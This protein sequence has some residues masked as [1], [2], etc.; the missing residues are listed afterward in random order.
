MTTPLSRIPISNATTRAAGYRDG[1]ELLNDLRGNNGVVMHSLAAG[2]VMAHH[3]STMPAHGLAQ[4]GDSQRASANLEQVL[5]VVESWLEAHATRRDEAAAVLVNAALEQLAPAVPRCAVTPAPR[6][7]LPRRVR[8][9]AAIAA[10]CLV[11]GACGWSL[12][13]RFSA[14]S[15][16][17]L[18]DLQL[19]QRAERMAGLILEE[20]RYEKDLFINID[21][22]DRLESYARKWHEVRAGLYDELARAEKLNLSEQDLKTLR[23]IEIDLR[24]Y[25][26]GYER[27]LLM[28]R[29]GDIRTTQ[30]AN[31]EFTRFKRAAHRIEAA[32]AAISERAQQRAA[33]LT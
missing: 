8:K 32:C 18:R 24:S 10:L 13:S 31:E 17:S 3:E 5:S 14:R 6:I 26:W 11:A 15:D 12:A 20:R 33:P 27:V 7:D 1:N 2:Y 25:A 9:T 21:D 30:A 22:R 28:I 16:Q 4:R 19:S 23:D 29:Q